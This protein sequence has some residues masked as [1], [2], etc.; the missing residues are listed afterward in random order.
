VIRDR[1]SPILTRWLNAYFQFKMRR[2]FRAVWMSGSLP[3]GD[4][5]FLVYANHTSFWDGFLA[6]AIAQHSSRD[7]YA[8]MEEHNL[9]RYRFLARVGAISIRRDDAR[10]AL[11]TFKYVTTVLTRPSATV[12]IF[13]QGKIISNQQRPLQLERGAALL[14][15]M[16]KVRCVPIAL[17]YTM[18]EHEFPDVLVSV[19]APHVATSIEEMEKN[20][21]ALCDE[22]SLRRDPS[23]FDVIVAGRQS[24]AE[25]WD[26]ARGMSA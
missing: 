15:R 11:E 1:K 10:S 20:L 12:F 22:L 23:G 19:G 13:P 17:R 6:Q 9:A 18:F 25:R 21:T 3:R 8:V 7:V 26:A 2:A 14:A 5:P 16:G 4:E 24:V